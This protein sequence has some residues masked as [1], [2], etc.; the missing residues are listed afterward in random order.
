M[1]NERQRQDKSAGGL[2]FV[3]VIIVIVITEFEV[4]RLHAARTTVQ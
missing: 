4:R 3:N 2:P 1:H